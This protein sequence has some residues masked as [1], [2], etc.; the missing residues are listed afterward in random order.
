[1]PPGF[2]SEHASGRLSFSESGRGAATSA[3]MR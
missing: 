2:G 1:V 3:R